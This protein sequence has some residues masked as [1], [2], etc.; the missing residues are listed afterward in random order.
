MDSKQ[1]HPI[2][3]ICALENLGNTCYM[4][5]VIQCLSATDILNH[6]IRNIYF[7][8]YLR[9]GIKRLYIEKLKKKK[10][11]ST[12]GADPG[13]IGGKE[14]GVGGYVPSG[15]GRKAPRR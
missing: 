15:I 11:A 5:S 9:E 13:E 4:N 6:H 3:G 7:K 10:S 12:R 14:G 8:D 1:G 2:I